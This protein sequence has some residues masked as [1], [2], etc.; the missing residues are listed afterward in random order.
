[1]KPYQII[2]FANTIKTTVG[3]NQVGGLT[4]NAAEKMLPK[5]NAVF[6]LVRFVNRPRRNALMG[7]ALLVN[8]AKCPPLDSQNLAAS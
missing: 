2:E 4:V 6:G 1:M 7:L 8:G 5:N 3:N